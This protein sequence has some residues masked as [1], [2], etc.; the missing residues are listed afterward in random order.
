MKALVSRA[1]SRITVGAAAALGCV[2]AGCGG[3]DVRVDP[4]GSAGEGSGSTGP[5]PAATH[6]MTGMVEGGEPPDTTGGHVDEDT[7]AGEDTSAAA[8]TEDD[9]GF[10][11]DYD[12]NHVPPCD[13]FENDCPRGFKCMPYSI[14]GGDTWNALACFPIADDPVG[15]GEVCEIEGNGVT[16]VDN[17]V[18]GAMCWDVD[19]RTLEGTCVA[20]CSGSEANPICTDPCTVCVGNAFGLCLHKCD[21][22]AQDCARGQ[23]CYAFNDT[24]ACAPDASGEVGVAGDPCECPHTRSTP[25]TPGIFC[26]L[27]MTFFSCPRALQRKV[28][29]F[30]ARPSSPARHVAS[31][32]LMP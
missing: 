15:V 20:M 6:G 28:N 21:P 24:F 3:P 32:M 27:P 25:T 9:G 1:T 7:S 11:V 14:D 5:G 12:T 10:I 26:N 13:A 2:V 30:V 18:A 22:V 16:G 19:P 8:T 4:P 23:A 31:L 29:V 17:C